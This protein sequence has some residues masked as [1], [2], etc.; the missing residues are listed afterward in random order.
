[1]KWDDWLAAALLAMALTLAAVGALIGCSTT[2][3]VCAD[4]C[5]YDRHW[6]NAEPWLCD[7]W[8]EDC[9]DSCPGHYA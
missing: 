2:R 9:I 3:Q 6:C 7:E 4:R 1:M 8:L 5:Y